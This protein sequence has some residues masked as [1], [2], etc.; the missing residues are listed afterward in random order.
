ML[1]TTVS[2]SSVETNT[3]QIMNVLKILRNHSNKMSELPRAH[4]V[5]PNSDSTTLVLR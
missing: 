1:L 2:S 4:G 5:G 3:S